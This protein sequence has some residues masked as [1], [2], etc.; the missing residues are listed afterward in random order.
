MNTPIN[1]ITIIIVLYEEETNLVLQC[2]ENIKD[3]KIIIVDNAGNKLLKKVVEKKFEIYKYVLNEKNLDLPK[4]FN[5]AVELCDTEYILNLQADCL[6]S[7]KDIS[8]LLKSHKEYDNCF[9]ASPTFYDKELKLTYNG[10]SLPEKNDKKDVLNLE[11]DVCVETILL[12]T[13]LFKKKDIFELGL[14]DE[15]FLGYYVDFELCRRVINKGGSIIQVFDAK[16]QHLHGQLKIKNYLKRTFVRNYYYTFDELY[17][18]FKINKHSEILKKLKKKLPNYIFKSIINL[19]LLRPT[20]SVY[21][22]SK[23][24]AFYKFNKFLNKKN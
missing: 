4:G 16:A 11:G 14:L 8:I 15:N 23:T 21:Y 12:S 10:G 3:F 24:V 5:Q 20:Q 19:F 18:F 1:E 22:F 2:L 17:Y 7:S 13:I 6:I 9:I